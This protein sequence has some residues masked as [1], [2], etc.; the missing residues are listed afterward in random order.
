[1]PRK[2]LSKLYRFRVHALQVPVA[3]IMRQ[4]WW[5][6][7]VV[8]LTGSGGKTT[9]THLLAHVLSGKAPT[10][11]CWLSRNQHAGITETIAFTN[12][13]KHRFCVFEIGA[14]QRRG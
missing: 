11:H 13:W 3:W 1:M 6:T 10:Q 5:R 14:G 8:A 7:E 2:L 4:S 12:P 9:A